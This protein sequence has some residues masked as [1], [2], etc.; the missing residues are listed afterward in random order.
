MRGEDVA[1][2][3]DV[4]RDDGEVGDFGEEE[5]DVERCA[6]IGAGSRMSSGDLMRPIGDMRDR[7][8]TSAG[9]DA[10]RTCCCCCCGVIST[11]FVAI[12]DVMVGIVTSSVSGCEG[13]TCVM[14]S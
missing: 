10:P 6:R 14:D 5:Q 13:G 1:A 4:M 7:K 2:G 11:C 9:V 12:G 3:D 8:S